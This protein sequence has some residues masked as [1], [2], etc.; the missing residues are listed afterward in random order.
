MFDGIPEEV[1]LAGLGEAS[2]LLSVPRSSDTWEEISYQWNR[3][4]I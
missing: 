3:K 2:T 4:E 1:R